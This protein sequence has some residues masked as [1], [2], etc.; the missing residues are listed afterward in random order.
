MK[1]FEVVGPGTGAKIKS[2]RPGVEAEVDHGDGVSTKIDL[3]QNPNALSK[4]SDGKVKM[5]K[6]G[7]KDDPAPERKMKP[8]QEVE[9]EEDI[10]TYTTNEE[11][12]ILEMLDS[13]NSWNRFDERQQQVINNM[14]RK[15]IV[16][17]YRDG[18]RVMV[19]K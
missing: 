5:N 14:N 18:D 15:G 3:K 12:D 9:I 10:A 17:K 16:H 7:S 1:I 8:G 6:P 11:A 2:V 19:K 13:P 4:T